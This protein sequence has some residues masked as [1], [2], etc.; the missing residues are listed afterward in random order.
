MGD[1]VSDI[2]DYQKTGSGIAIGQIVTTPYTVSTVIES[3]ANTFLKLGQ[4]I[5]DITRADYPESFD[6]MA[7]LYQ[8][9][10]DYLN[11]FVSLLGYWDSNVFQ[12]SNELDLIYEGST[13]IT[14][15]NGALFL[16]PPNTTHL[17]KTADHG[18]SWT[19]AVPGAE[20][21]YPVCLKVLGGVLYYITAADQPEFTTT[22]HYKTA[23]GQTW[24]D[25]GD[26]N[27]TVLAAADPLGGIS[28]LYSDTAHSQYIEVSANFSNFASVS[29]LD[30]PVGVAFNQSL[31]PLFYDVLYALPGNTS[32]TR[33]DLLLLDVAFKSNT[34]YFLWYYT[35]QVPVEGESY[36]ETKN[37]AII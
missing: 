5:S 31:D 17:F 20:Q 7:G 24:T 19:L 29:T 34:A 16:V 3:D 28:M 23:D 2:H 6:H 9:S 11:G 14:F 30:V 13:L 18:V 15:F 10:Y 1:L 22:H 8:Y 37:Y 35:I 33:K 36:K 27:D 26:P 25:Y 32:F 12:F 21:E 4:A